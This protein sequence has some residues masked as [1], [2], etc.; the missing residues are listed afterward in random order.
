MSGMLSGLT[1]LLTRDEG[2][3]EELRDLGA[4]VRVAEVLSY[5]AVPFEADP[6]AFDWIV[7][8]SRRA[9]AY[10]ALPLDSGPRVACVGPATGE[11]IRERGGS[12]DL[13]PASHNATALAD[14]LIAEGSVAGARVLFP[15]SAAALSVI[16]E[17]LGAAGAKVTRVTAYR[18][19][20]NDAIAPEE[21]LGADVVVFLAPSA[22]AA[23]EELLGEFKSPALA[24]GPTT[25]AALIERGVTPLTA[26][27]S[28][29]PGLIEALRMFKEQR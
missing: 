10:S 27:T 5:E 2:L 29:R 20:L 11:A 26:P 7:F 12:V 9:V 4:D 3:A 19:V 24:I 25:A 18:P 17:K 6:A 13:M 14:A 15:A 22:V 8:T 23:F 1:V 21:L 16:E 28:D